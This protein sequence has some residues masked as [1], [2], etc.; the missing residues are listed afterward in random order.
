MQTGDSKNE[1]KRRKKKNF[2]ARTS[3]PPAPRS[4]SWGTQEGYGHPQPALSLAGVPSALLSFHLSSLSSPT[5]T[6]PVAS[7][8]SRR[9]PSREPART[10]PKEE[11]MARSGRSRSSSASRRPTAAASRPAAKTSVP[12]HPPAARPPPAVAPAP[13]PQQPGLFAQMASTA[14]VSVTRRLGAARFCAGACSLCPLRPFRSVDDLGKGYIAGSCRAPLFLFVDAFLF[15]AQFAGWQRQVVFSRPSKLALSSS[16][17]YLPFFFRFLPFPGVAVGSAVGHTIGAGISGLFGG[18][19]SSS[20]TAAQQQQEQ[21]PAQP[22]QQW[23][24]SADLSSCDTDARAFTSCLEKYNNDMTMCEW[25]LNNLRACQ[26][27]FRHE[28]SANYSW[29]GSLAARCHRAF[30]SPPAKQQ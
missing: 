18:N 10:P 26:N 8:G 30:G 13:Q 25:Y 19:G 6:A 16:A 14:A 29:D 17:E 23:N 20:E 22:Q 27:Q 2:F 11:A 9:F 1:E 15:G 3:Q 4:I 24:Q 5:N 21:A 7:T 28:A 12:A